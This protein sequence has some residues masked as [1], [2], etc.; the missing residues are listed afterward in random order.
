MVCFSFG[1]FGV[2]LVL[3][4]RVPVACSSVFPFILSLEVFIMH[5]CLEPTA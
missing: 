4:W 5:A 2:V 1:M 3:H